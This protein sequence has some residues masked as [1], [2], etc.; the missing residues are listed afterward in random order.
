MFYFLQ[1]V[2]KSLIKFLKSSIIKCPDFRKSKNLVSSYSYSV[3]PTAILEYFLTLPT[4]K[5]Q[6]DIE[7]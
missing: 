3:Q 5:P 7:I 6:I 1:K 4:L 2:P